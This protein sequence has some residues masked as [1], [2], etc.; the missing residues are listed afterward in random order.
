MPIYMYRCGECSQTCEALQHSTDAP[1]VECPHCHAQTL[2]KI[3][4]PVGIIFKGHGF[5]KTDNASG[6]I[7]DDHQ[8]DHDNSDT[9]VGE[10]GDHKAAETKPTEPAAKT[11]ASA[12]SNSSEKAPA[13]TEKNSGGGSSSS[14]PNSGKVA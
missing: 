10:S 8:H 4:A 14:S 9:I 11:E 6:S 1:L 13:V 3:I 5:Y 2:H 12:V 7:H